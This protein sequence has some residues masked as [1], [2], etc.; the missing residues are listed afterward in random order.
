MPT[1][2]ELTLTYLQATTSYNL[3]KRIVSPGNGGVT[4]SAVESPPRLVK[5]GSSQPS[6]CSPMEVV[7]KVHW[8]VLVSDSP[9]VAMWRSMMDRAFVGVAEGD[10]GVDDGSE[11]GVDVV[12]EACEL[13][14]PEVDVTKVVEL[15]LIVVE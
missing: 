8:L 4:I 10:D 9:L 5:S 6:A 11:E 2:V 3:S 7:K 13:P 12:S 15:E 14:A 1:S